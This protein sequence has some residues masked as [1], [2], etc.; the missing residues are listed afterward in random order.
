MKILQGKNAII[1]GANRGIGHQ[2][3]KTFA[4]EGCHI[5]ACARKQSQ[6]F[7][8][9]LH[10]IAE[11]NKVHVEPVYFD[12]TDQTQMKSA[13]SSIQKGK[14]QIDILVNCAGIFQVAPFQMMKSEDFRK[15]FET[16]FFGPVELIRNITRLM[17][18]WKK[19]SIIN[20]ASVSGID[21]HPGNTAYGSSKAALIM[22][23]QI[24][25]SELAKLGIRVNAIAP[26]NTDTEMIRPMTNNVGREAM[27]DITAMARFAKPQEIADAAVFLASDKSSFITG[28]VIRVDGGRT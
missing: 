8:D 7:E 6:E 26:G 14:M 2:I 22:F 4:K 17:T 16:D 27:L 21:P 23:T 19:G 3:V 1:T 25:A 20:I 28:E 15:I 13:V 10:E 12:I 5:W 9:D 11:Q 18:H 24:L